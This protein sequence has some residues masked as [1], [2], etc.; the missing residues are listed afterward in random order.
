MKRT[1]ES[2]MESKREWNIR[3]RRKC[4]IGSGLRLVYDSC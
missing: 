1:A 3:V 2:G 4:E